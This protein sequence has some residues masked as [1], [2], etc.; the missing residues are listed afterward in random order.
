M[1]CPLAYVP[2]TLLMVLALG[3]AATVSGCAARRD[4]SASSARASTPPTA[5]PAPRGVEARAPKIEVRGLANI[6]RTMRL[7]TSSS[8]SSPQRVRVLLYGQSITQSSWSRKLE[9]V[10]RERFP[11]AALQIENRSLGGFDAQ[12]LAK[13]AESD[14]YTSYPDLV[15]FHVYG[16]HDRY[17]D[18]VRRL[19][20]RTTAEVLLQTD[21]VTRPEDLTEQT[22]RSKLA[23]QGAMWS[24]F[25][26][27]AFL[28]GLVDEQ[29][30]A[31][32]DVRSAWKQR[33]RAR[34]LAPSALLSDEVHL[35]P[36]GDAWMAAFV[37]ACLVRAPALDPAP[38][39]SWV[40]T[41]DLGALHGSER[42]LRIAFEGNRI[43]AVLRPG[44]ARTL[45]VEIDGKPPSAYP[46]SYA[47]ARAHATQS[48]KWPPIYDLGTQLD[49][50]GTRL[51]ETFMLDVQRQ[52][53]ARG[54]LYTFTVTGTRTGPDGSGSS[55]RTFVSSSGRLVIEPGDWVADYA[56]QLAGAA[57]PPARFQIALRVE[58]HFTD[59]IGA[60][61]PD[62]ADE[63]VVTL[64][65]GLSNTRHELVLRLDA[66]SDQTSAPQL[67]S[68]RIYR[69]PLDRH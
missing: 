18:I 20:E 64:A 2:L 21:H 24:A 65:A 14:L 69:P 38:A 1:R 3:T 43:E 4:V 15:I 28:P 16:A 47:F 58:P 17:G 34:G 27:N 29:Q 57:P 31:L 49:A 35:N 45:A 62:G 8:A 22:D 19:R 44:P 37:A 51:V 7:L 63:Q 53:T 50:A 10:L 61:S 39:D 26:N 54:G 5:Q 11:H 30:A 67:V 41:L 46:A 60:A 12:Y 13:A 23:P 52:Q 36:E 59:F 66:A 32:C 55:D 9:R 6:Q 40:Q 48:G 25:M 33:L 68:L 56:F 42:E